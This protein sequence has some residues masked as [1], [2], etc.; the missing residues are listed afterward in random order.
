M[1]DE[2]TGTTVVGG[3]L[4]GAQMSIYQASTIAKWF[5]DKTDTT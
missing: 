4:G 3:R 1:S 2:I 5:I